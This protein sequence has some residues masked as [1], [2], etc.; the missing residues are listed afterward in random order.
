MRIR[1]DD[2]RLR[3]KSLIP[4]VVMYLTVFG[5]AGFGAY[6]LDSVSRK[7]EDLIGNQD[8]TAIYVARATREAM[9]GPYSAMG[10]LIYESSSP[11]GRTAQADFIAQTDAFATTLQGLS[12]GAPDYDSTFEG[13][14]K[15]LADIKDK[16]KVAMAVSEDSPGL[17]AGR[18]LTPQM[19]DKL[20][21]GAG[22]VADIDS[23]ARDMASG[24]LNIDDQMISDSVQSVQELA[25]DARFD[26]V[27]LA[28]A[29]LASSVAAGALMAWVTGAKIARPLVDLAAR[30]K[31][32]AQGDLGVEIHGADRKDEIGDISRAILELQRHARERLRL[33][34]VADATRRDADFERERNLAERTNAQAQQSDAIARLGQGLH[35]LAGGDLTMRMDQSFSVEY[36]ALRDDFNDAAQKLEQAIGRVAGAADAIRSGAREISSASGEVAQRTERQAAS[37]EETAAAIE[38]IGATMKKSAAGAAS[39]REIVGA[40]DSDAKRSATVVRQAVEAMDEIAASARQINQI[41]G[42]IDDIAFQTNLLAL[43]A[44]VEAARAGDSGRGFAVVASEVR[45]LSQRSAEAAKE[46]KQLVQTSSAKVETGVRLV[47]QTGKALER[48]VEQVS[49]VNAIIA[50]IANGA[51]EQAAALE[52]VNAAVSEMDRSTQENAIMVDKSSAATRDLADQIEGLADLVAQFRGAADRGRGGAGARSRLAA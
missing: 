24:L 11:E 21:K 1:L 16:G 25:R 52:G 26:L 10:A 17:A 35:A 43:N 32:L 6:R 23:A 39:A 34:R 13:M 5:M 28:V 20:G 22:V 48:I 36:A 42:V 50:D 29:A 49:G 19:L 27:G 30:A 31:S 14:R 40:A 41:I 3:T 8:K 38:E 46:I 4:L 15:S 37:L 44:G 7:A 51:R 33:E 2:L 12:K 47:D 9:M 18:N 45:A